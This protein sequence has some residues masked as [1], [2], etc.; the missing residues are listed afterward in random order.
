MIPCIQTLA[1]LTDALR[2]PVYHHLREDEATLL[3]GEEK[4]YEFIER[5]IKAAS[6]P[7]ATKRIH[8]GMDEAWHL[9]LGAYLQRHGLR[10][11][12]DIMNE[13]L[14]RVMAIVER[15]GLQ[16]MIWSDMYFRAA[17]RRGDYYDMEARIPPEIAAKIPKQLQLVYWD[18]YHYETDVYRDFIRRHRALGSDPIFAGG[19]WNWL[20]F[21]VNWGKT[22]RTTNPALTACKE[23]GIQEVFA[24]LWGDNGTECNVYSILLGLQ[25]F[26]E[27]GYARVVDEERL[28]RRFQFCTGACYDDVLQFKYLDEIPGVSEDNLETCNASK[29]L[30]WQDP[31]TG[32]FDANIAGLPLAAHYERLAAHLRQAEQRNGAY[33]RVFGYLAAA[34]EVLA[35]KAEIGLAITRAYRADDRHELQRIAGSVLPDLISRVEKLHG[36]HRDLWLATYKALGW[37]VIDMRYGALLARLR[38]AGQRLADFL[39]G[40]CACL[41]ELDEP[42]RSY[43]GRTG[44]SRYVNHYADMVSASRIAARG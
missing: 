33:N 10:S 1:H 34:S 11:K 32:L 12:F 14:E 4:V 42:R 21:G 5:L 16:P 26:A 24:T 6:A 35:L 29:F 18:Y 9:G 38:T 15:L 25:L 7:F 17:S 20:S 41:E 31:L 3:V 39:A 19:I 36:I 2:W 37:E 22:F 13:H 23:E 30:M 40:R 43:N 27:H 8:I 44:V 28:N